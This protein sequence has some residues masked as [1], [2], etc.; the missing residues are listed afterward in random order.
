MDNIRAQAVLDLINTTNTRNNIEDDIENISDSDILTSVYSQCFIFDD[1]D[2]KKFKID[3]SSYG[4]SIIE[5]FLYIYSEAFDDESDSQRVFITEKLW[6][7]V[8]NAKPNSDE[9]KAIRAAV[10][11][12]KLLSCKTTY[13][14]EILYECAEY[15]EARKWYSENLN[16]VI[17]LVIALALSTGQYIEAM[18]DVAQKNLDNND[19]EQVKAVKLLKNWRCK[20]LNEYNQSGK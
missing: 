20:I 17:V 13:Y 11:L 18:Y 9:K 7:I 1:Y 12:D 2:T 16:P 5:S 15:D 14:P 4:A 8:K 6:T 10:K 3:T 19:E